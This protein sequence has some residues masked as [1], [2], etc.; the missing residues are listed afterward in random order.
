[1]QE[2]IMDMSFIRTYYD[3]FPKNYPNIK[4]LGTFYNFQDLLASRDSGEENIDG[5]LEFLSKEVFKRMMNEEIII[6]EPFFEIIKENYPDVKIGRKLYN[7][8]NRDFLPNLSEIVKNGK[9]VNESIKEAVIEFSK[10]NQD[11]K[12]QQRGD[13]I[14]Y[15]QHF[16]KEIIS[17]GNDPNEIKHWN[18]KVEILLKNLIL[19]YAT[20]GN[21]LPTGFKPNMEEFSIESCELFIKVMSI[22]LQNKD[23]N[24]TPGLNDNIDILTLLYVRNGRKLL[25]RDGKWTQIIENLGL[26]DKYIHPLE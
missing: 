10:N 20:E 17:E 18:E 9:N 16:R 4:L 19:K 3:D 11:K 2:C 6:W 13:F 14:K 12:T 22:F 24:L 26:N 23:G 8:I 1:M 25:M 21:Y 5:R 7:R 15:S